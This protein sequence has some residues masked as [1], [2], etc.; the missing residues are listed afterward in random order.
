[1]QEKELRDVVPP[2]PPSKRKLR[3]ARRL[4][5]KEKQMSEII[6]DVVSY[7]MYIMVLLFLCHG[8][9]DSKGQVINE[10]LKKTFVEGKYGLKSVCYFLE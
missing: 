8:N 6:W 1:L 7:F 5:A 3:K 10:H 2:K 4:R 9:R